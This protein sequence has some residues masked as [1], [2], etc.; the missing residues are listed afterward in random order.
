MYKCPPDKRRK[1]IFKALAL[2]RKILLSFSEAGKDSD[3]F[4]PFF[5]SKKD[6]TREDKEYA[7]AAQMRRALNSLKERK[8]IEI[9]KKGAK[10]VY[11]LTDKG[12]LAALKE[13]I[14]LADRRRDGKILLVSFDIPEQESLI[15]DKF[16]RL[17]KDFEFER[18]Q[19]SLWASKQDVGAELVKLIKEMGAIKWIRIFE[20]ND[21]LNNLFDDN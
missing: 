17:L 1:K 12:R 7:E 10:M 16:R 14:R 18:V 13:R 21:I 8:F 15:R 4:N 19:F 2:T 3:I 20:A 11:V 6:W 9:R 5:Y